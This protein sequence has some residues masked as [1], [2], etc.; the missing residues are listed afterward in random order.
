MLRR[1]LVDTFGT[2][3]VFG[4]H[5][6]NKKQDLGAKSDERVHKRRDE[7]KNNADKQ[8][9]LL[10]DLVQ[11]FA[12]VIG[13]GTDRE[14]EV[15][16]LRYQLNKRRCSHPGQISDIISDLLSQ[17]AKRGSSGSQSHRT[18]SQRYWPHCCEADRPLAPPTTPQYWQYPYGCQ[19]P[20]MAIPNGRH[21][22]R[23]YR[24]D[25]AKHN[26]KYCPGTRSRDHENR[27]KSRCGHIPA[28]G[29]SGFSGVVTLAGAAEADADAVGVRQAA[30]IAGGYVHR[31]E[32]FIANMKQQREKRELVER[33][34]SEKMADTE[35]RIRQTPD[36]LAGL[37]IHLD[38]SAACNKKLAKDSVTNKAKAGLLERELM[39]L[40]YACSRMVNDFPHDLVVQDEKIGNIGTKALRTTCDRDTTKLQLAI[41]RGKPYGERRQLR[42]DIYGVDM[43]RE[44]QGLGIVDRACT[45]T[46]KF[47][48]LWTKIH[49]SPYP[50]TSI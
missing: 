9:S 6:S 1:A 13:V 41:R 18:I 40:D 30:E 21:S 31:V 24:E 10:I 50:A 48:E 17:D 3:S 8:P 35:E 28:T 26:A 29:S 4:E 11:K 15:A 42:E 20:T 22:R 16:H 7:L 49:S 23:Q 19:V 38:A 46:S 14:K 12:G 36:L 32:D 5:Q 27:R 37:G 43:T 2:Q 47:E 25:I 39:S 34:M 45:E 33:R 44:A